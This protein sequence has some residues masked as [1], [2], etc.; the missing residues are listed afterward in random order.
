MGHP[1]YAFERAS[2]HGLDIAGTA[3]ESY[4]P[5]AGKVYIYICRT[6]VEDGC[7]ANAC[8]NVRAS[9]RCARPLVINI[10]T[11]YPIDLPIDT[12]SC[13]SSLS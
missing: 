9:A 10:A 1:I 7:I 8:V 13:L 3:A 5:S 2:E 4:P 12:S 6:S 11:L